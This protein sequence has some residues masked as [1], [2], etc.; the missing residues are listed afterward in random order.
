[1][2]SSPAVTAAAPVRVNDRRRLVLAFWAAA[3]LSVL[4]PGLP[5][6]RMAL[7]PFALLA[8]WAHEMGHGLTALMVG[9]EF[10]RLLLFA[11]LGGVA[12]S[13]RPDNV[14][15][16]VLISAGGL[17][18]PALAGGLVVVLGAR[19]RASRLVLGGLAAALLASAGDWVRNP[20]GIAAVL[21][22]GLGCA[23]MA[24]YGSEVA[25]QVATQLIGIQLCLGSL[26][27]F[28][29][30]FTREFVRDG[31]V[32]ISDTQAIADQLFLP[33]WFWGALIAALSLV[34]LAVAFRLAWVPSRRR[35]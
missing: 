12:Y 32:R 33:Y 5:F 2:N 13:A 7:Y 34:I 35:A 18:G 4:L 9:G 16:P 24:I 23:G 20:F 27:D 14:V 1:M 29:Y 22:L 30:M 25:R 19:A 31:Q 11:D 21:G 15:A 8:T 10:E 28:D 17:L 3:G 26:S 6:G